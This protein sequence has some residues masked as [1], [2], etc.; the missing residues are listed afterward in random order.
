MPIKGGGVG[1][2]GAEQHTGDVIPDADQDFGGYRLKG[3]KRFTSVPSAADLGTDGI[4]L[5]EITTYSWDSFTKLMLHMNGDDGSQVFTDEI[6]KTVTANGNAQIDTAIKK[7]GTGSGLFDGVGDFLSLADSDDW[8]FGTGAFTIDFWIYR[9]GNQADYAGVVSGALGTPAGWTIHFGNTATG[10]ANKLRFTALLGGVWTTLLTS[11]NV[12]TNQTWVHIAIVRSNNNWYMFIGGALDNS[13]SNSNACNS[14]DSGM[15]I[16][17]LYTG[18]D[19]YY[20]TG[21]L[22]ELRVSKG[23]AR[24]TEAFTP[25]D[26]EYEADQPSYARRLYANI[27]GNVVGFVPEL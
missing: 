23:V 10:T 4:G 25:P 19:N 16:G 8:D 11:T 14:G 24:W 21:Q 18:T 6:G 3:L 1:V 5:A 2:H 22:D 15:V 9:N 27:N 20:F 7:F 13:G 12:I 26:A 17:R